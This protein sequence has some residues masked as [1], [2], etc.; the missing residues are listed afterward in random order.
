M[1]TDETQGQE[2]PERFTAA[3]DE[4]DTEGHRF[5]A[6]SG[7]AEGA[8]APSVRT[9]VRTADRAEDDDTEGHRF[10]AKTGDPD[11]GGQELGVHTAAR[12]DDDDTEGHIKVGGH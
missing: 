3:T 10:T 9:A 4:E 1:S 8:E 12:D 2:A 6:M 5:T 7:D 11:F